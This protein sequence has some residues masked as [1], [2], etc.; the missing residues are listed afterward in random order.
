MRRLWRPVGDLQ[1]LFTRGAQKGFL[2]RDEVPKVDQ[3]HG[4]AAC[5]FASKTE[6]FG[7]LRLQ[8]ALFRSRCASFVDS[9][10]AVLTK[11]RVAAYQAALRQS[12]KP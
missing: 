4:A 2:A 3:D 1:K 8:G 9:S 6:H 12:A 5:S 10:N 11:E 7:K